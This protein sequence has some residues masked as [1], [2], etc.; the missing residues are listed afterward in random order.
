MEQT[1]QIR[2]EL[3]GFWYAYT[4]K[5]GEV[6]A[7]TF[8][9]EKCERMELPALILPHFVFFPLS[10]QRNCLITATRRECLSMRNA[11]Y[12]GECPIIPQCRST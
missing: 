2:Q 11:P 10:H 1:M 4:E 6:C 3:S 5:D 12:R 9:E 8:S 7:D